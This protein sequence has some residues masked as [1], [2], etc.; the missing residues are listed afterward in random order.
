MT[1]LT[2]FPVLSIPPTNLQLHKCLVQLPFK[3]LG[4]LP[5]WQCAKLSSEVAWLPPTK[6]Y[7]CVSV[8][9]NLLLAPKKRSLK[10]YISQ[11]LY[12]S[13][14]WQGRWGWTQLCWDLFHLQ[15]E[16]LSVSLALDSGW[17][18]RAHLTVDRRSCTW[19]ETWVYLT[20]QNKTQLGSNSLIFFSFFTCCLII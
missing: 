3:S 1:D 15:R 12:W 20:L 11:P 7:N 13:A 4:V 18:R 19:R 9:I 10:S 8:W 14:E 16:A 17:R 5:Q 2:Y 6:L